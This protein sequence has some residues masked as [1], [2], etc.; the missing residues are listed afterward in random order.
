MLFK[1]GRSFLRCDAFLL[2]TTS[3]TP[4]LL[5]T[6]LSEQSHLQHGEYIAIFSSGDHGP[7][8][9]KEGRRRHQIRDRQGIH[10]VVI[11]HI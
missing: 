9:W 5:H 3:L 11:V 2:P 6:P 8:N 10:G 1:D 4:Y 7:S